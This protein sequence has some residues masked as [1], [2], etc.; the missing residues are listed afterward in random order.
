MA[1]KPASKR[2]PVQRREESQ[3]DQSFATRHQP[4]VSNALKIKLDHLKT[5]EALT[6]NQQIFFD[7]YRSGS[8]AFMLMGSPGTGKS[9]LLL[10][11]F[12]DKNYY[13]KKFNNLYLITLRIALHLLLIIHLKIIQKYITT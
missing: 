10:S 2:T 12:R 8:Y 1:T 13:K 3:S 9:S 4:V 5:F 7:A 11:L 6:E